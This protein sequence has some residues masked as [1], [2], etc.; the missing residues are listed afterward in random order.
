MKK[1]VFCVL[2]ALALLLNACGKMPVETAPTESTPPATATTPETEPAPQ[3]GNE[4]E[5]ETES[6]EN[7]G[8]ETEPRTGPEQERKTI[9]E[10]YSHVAVIGVDGAGAFFKDADTPE[11]DRIVENGAVTYRALTSNPTISAQSWGSM[12]TGVVP[13]CHRLTNSLIAERPYPA[14]SQ[15]PTVFRV[16]RE[17]MP[18]A[19]LGSFATWNPINTGIADDGLDI[20]KE[21][22]SGDGELCGKIC[23]YV[24]SEKP[25]FLFV[26]FDDVDATGH[27]VGYGTEGHL[28]RI[29]FTDG[30]IGRV[31]QAFE[32]AGIADDTL[33][34]FTADHGGTG[35]SHGGWSDAE[36][37]IMIAAAGKNVVHG[38][39]GNVEVRDIASVVLMGLG[40][41][42]KQPESWTARVPSG[43]FE[44]VEAKERPVYEIRYAYPHRT[45]EVSPTPEGDASV[46]NLLGRDRIL[47]YLP[48]DGSIQPVGGPIR[49]KQGGK[50]Y[51]TDGYFGQGAAFDDGYVTLGGWKPE[52]KSFSVAFWMKT[53]GVLVDPCLLSNK[54]W[55]SGLNPG[56]VLALRE[57]D[58]K[59]NAGSG[60]QIRMDA[61]YP[62]PIDFRGGWVYVVLVVDRDAG[63]VRFSYDFAPLE[64]A[65]TEERLAEFAP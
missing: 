11:L 49:A 12:L 7:A 62:L 45:H 27:S 41:E 52:K 38:E 63:E 13:E 56:F 54:D 30:L 64:A 4:P 61:E 15:F 42:D 36:K 40:L 16:I 24:A 31:H 33:F 39:I 58:V 51:F 17:A 5:A 60:G 26:Q 23:E 20:H 14:D 55:M 28:A 34:I 37:Y 22:A 8:S 43:L 1:R 2:C 9:I 6:R 57:G 46:V 25:T 10:P 50:L 47:T 29:T 35:M 59:F 19:K 3:S 44:G 21:T 65:A 48:F 53:D 32:E 18:D